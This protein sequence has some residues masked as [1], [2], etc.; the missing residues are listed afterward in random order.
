MLQSTGP[1]ASAMTTEDNPEE[2]TDDAVAASAADLARE[3]AD[4]WMEAH[5]ARALAHERA[6]LQALL[7]SRRRS[8]SWRMTAPLRRAHAALGRIRSGQRE[9]PTDRETSNARRA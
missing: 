9:S 3:R 8:L 5:R 1:A 7:D 6:R 4:L 2:R